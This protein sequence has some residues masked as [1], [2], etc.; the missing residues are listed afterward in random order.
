M[1]KVYVLL[2]NSQQNGPYSLEELLEFDLKP[3]DLIW[4][5]GKSAG[6]YYP[7]E[8]EA[9]LPHLPFVKQTVTEISYQEQIRP[10]GTV[11][12]KVFVSMPV[13]G[14]EQTNSKPAFTREVDPSPQT[15]IKSQASIDAD[16][17]IRTSYSR[18]LE[19][20]ESDYTSRVYNQSKK[21]KKGISRK[22]LA[23]AAIIV[24]I[25]VFAAVTIQ[26]FSAAPEKAV[27]QTENPSVTNSEITPQEAA[28]Q[29]TANKKPR[30]ATTKKA[31]SKTGSPV[32][33]KET[34][35]KV[36]SSSKNNY[37][38]SVAST[39]TIEI[40]QDEELAKEQPIVKE[41]SKAVVNGAPK[42]QKKKLKE[43]FLDLFKKKEAP[44]K[45]EAKPVENE[46]GERRAVRRQ[47][48]ATLAEQV[49]VKFTI[50]NDWMMGIKAAKVSLTNKS[51]QTIVKATIEV[52]YY[53]EENELLQT[54]MVS[55]GKI[56][57]KE[58]GTV[59]IPDHSFADHVE[60]KI[61]SVQGSGE[62]FAK[63]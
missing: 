23:A 53:N 20:V 37:E 55:F 12:K 27:T 49:H 29:L 51:N 6:W 32:I 60:Y 13:N 38:A 25:A 58:T 48:D 18:S 28:V 59:S 52:F 14:T 31:L 16:A 26:H 19:D 39:N 15:N 44:Q 57:A 46:D 9:L 3:V 41:D 42:E 10:A 21:K 22:G 30:G 45:E 7:Q 8:I 47:L 33:V 61:I 54:K 4:I 24:A 35:N 36:S 40:K 1:Q 2:R 50:P 34:Y 63:L 17:D 62:P 5:E 56:A 11:Q 43:K